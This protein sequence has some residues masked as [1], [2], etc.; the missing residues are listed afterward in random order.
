VH[1]LIEPFSKFFSFALNLPT[2]F[3]FDR[4]LPLSLVVR[5]KKGP[6]PATEESFPEVYVIGDCVKI[7]KIGDAV[8]KG[9]MTGTRI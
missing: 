8:H 2:S 3:P 5:D 9:Y 7:G 6:S 1:I 4:Y